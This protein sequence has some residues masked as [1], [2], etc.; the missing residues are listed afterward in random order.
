V[1][2]CTD[3]VYVGP[4]LAEAPQWELVDVLVEFR[5]V[6][7]VGGVIRIGVFDF[8]AAIRA[9]SEGDVDFF[10]DDSWDGLAGRMA[11]HVLSG[12]AARSVLTAALLRELLGRAG[13]ADIRVEPFGSSSV[14]RALAAPDRFEQH[15]CH[16]EARNATTWPAPDRPDR[17]TGVHLAWADPRCDS[18]DVLWSA[19]SASQGAVRYRAVGDE[20]WTTV[21]AR[22]WPTIDGTHSPYVFGSTCRIPA[23]GR[24]YEYEVTQRVGD[25]IPVSPRSSFTALPE[26][27]GARIRFAFIADTG[28]AGR[29]DGLTDGTRRVVR[30]VRD[31]APHF[32]LGG[33]DYAYMSTD[34]RLAS[35]QQAVR[36]WLREVEPIAT[37][38]PLMVQ[39]GNH[40]VG[41]GERHRDWAVHFPQLR[42]KLTGSA[43]SYSFDAGPCHV[44]A[45]YAPTEDVSPDETAWLWQD[46]AAARD[47]GCRWLVVFQHQPLL[48]HGSSHPADG[49][50]ERALARVLE[51]HRV[52]LHLSAHDQN[53][54]RTHPVVWAGE[55][56]A[57]VNWVGEA[58]SSSRF[59]QGAGVIL[60]KVSPAGKRS[61]RGRDFSTLRPTLH[62]AVAV[63]DD[64]AH[65]FAVVEVDDSAL[66]LTTY[67]LGGADAPLERIDHVV[68]EGQ[69]RE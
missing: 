2:A 5:R 26:E 63:A 38:C 52:D 57:R 41:M 13:F 50:V 9:Y 29:P 25:D 8:D 69:N 39:Y 33:G 67:G 30:E 42:T 61:D 54:E 31:A 24:Q 59:P 3:Q 18:V 20:E 34:P 10:W 11:S 7:R 6:L 23:R 36:A 47:R 27:G 4:S 68:I 56:G 53:Y 21:P 22:S 45:F 60:A 46:L 51:H 58:E 44:A 14:G 12:G 37:S 62:P 28:I 65:H 55:G 32:V 43:R 49:R 19:P 15:C 48:A 64:A 35:G 66:E 17:P 1:T 16:V 40:E